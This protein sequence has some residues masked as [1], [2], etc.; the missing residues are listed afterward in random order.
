MPVALLL[1]HDLHSQGRFT[2]TVVV[3]GTRRTITRRLV[4]VGTR[5]RV[6]TVLT[7]RARRDLAVTGRRTLVRRV[8]TVLTRTRRRVAVV[9]VGTRRTVTR[10]VVAWLSAVDGAPVRHAAPSTIPS[11]RFPKRRIVNSPLGVSKNSPYGA[12]VGLGMSPT[13]TKESQWPTKEDPREACREEGRAL[14]RIR[15]GVQGLRKRGRHY[16]APALAFL[17]AIESAIGRLLQFGPTS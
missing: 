6:G 1:L 16:G 7:T 13:H 14:P 17:T 15:S 2:S 4:D 8:F 5:L 9:A 3:A 11:A 12:Q 10:C